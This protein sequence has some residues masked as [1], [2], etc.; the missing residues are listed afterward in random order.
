MTRSDEN[1]QQIARE[2]MAFV[3]IFG[4]RLW[5]DLHDSTAFIDIPEPDSLYVLTVDLRELSGALNA[6]KDGIVSV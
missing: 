3:N 6:F 1:R 4:A 5:H 2:Q